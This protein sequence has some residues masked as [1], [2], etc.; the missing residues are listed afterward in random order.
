MK[1]LQG[2]RLCSVYS[3]ECGDLSYHWRTLVPTSRDM[4]WLPSKHRI[5]NMSRTMSG[6]HP[7]PG[8]HSWRA[9]PSLQAH[10]RLQSGGLWRPVVTKAKEHA[11]EGQARMHLQKGQ[12]T[13]LGPCRVQPSQPPDK[14]CPHQVPWVFQGVSEKQACLRTFSTALGG[15]RSWGRWPRDR[16]ERLIF[17]NLNTHSSETRHPADR[18]REHCNC[19]TLQQ[20]PL[21]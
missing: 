19:P 2:P 10:R 6:L 9:A 16:E 1:G 13:A 12:T 3:W 4:R 18:N 17:F 8:P 5:Q 11:T 14:G 7:G 15:H 20:S 21:S